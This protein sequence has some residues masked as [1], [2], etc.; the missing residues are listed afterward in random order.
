MAD[1]AQTVPE[2]DSSL[3]ALSVPRRTL[4]DGK[5]P[6]E[7]LKYVPEESAEHYRFVPMAVVDGVLEVGMVDPDNIAAIDALNFITRKT[8]MPFKVF[9]ISDADLQKV[10]AMYR[11][12]GGDVDR[13]VSDLQ[14]EQ[15]GRCVP[16]QSISLE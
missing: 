2:T 1:T 4:T 13:A 5:V 9:Q 7:V 3:V 11:G 12:L 6:Y 14:T 16:E 15:K 8:G 10:I